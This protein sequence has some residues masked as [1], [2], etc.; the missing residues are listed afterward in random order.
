MSKLSDF[1]SKFE[2]GNEENP[3]PDFYIL[4]GQKEMPDGDPLLYFSGS[5][6]MSPL[7]TAGLLGQLAMM[8]VQGAKEMSDLDKSTA[9]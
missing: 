9:H 3:E 6:A 1:V 7:K 5:Q 8:L 4:I 2:K